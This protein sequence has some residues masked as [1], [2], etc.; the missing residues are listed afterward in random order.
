MEV[1]NMDPNT[2]L[3][4]AL[5]LVGTTLQPVTEQVVK[6]GYA[7]LKSL[8]VRKFGAASPKLEPT[9]AE[10]AEDP[11]TYAKPATKVLHE[12]GVDADQEVLD[13]AVELL[14]RAEATLPNITGGLVG[15]INAGGGRV[16]LIGR[17]ATGSIQLGDSYKSSR[18]SDPTT[19]AG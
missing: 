2:V 4:S 19:S 9:L 1:R 6:D 16:V 17:D 5:S 8:I 18:P 11:D 14:K 15:Q 7:G 13:A 3:L 12:A 10:Y